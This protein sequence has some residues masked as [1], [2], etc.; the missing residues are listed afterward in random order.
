[1]ED[2]VSI[3]TGIRPWKFAHVFNVP[4]PSLLRMEFFVFLFFSAKMWGPLKP[5][6]LQKIQKPKHLVKN[7]KKRK[8]KHSLKARQGHI[9]HVCKSSG[10]NSQKRRGHWRLKEFGV[11][12]LNQPVPG[13]EYRVADS[14][15]S[16]R[17]PSNVKR[18]RSYS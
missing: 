6:Y 3:V 17:S 10:S 16:S 8:K 14:N 13:I 2:R 18:V 1:M 7:T 15:T 5:K 11:L 12:C 4:L 9:K